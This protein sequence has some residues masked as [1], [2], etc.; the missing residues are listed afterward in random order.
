MRTTKQNHTLVRRKHQGPNMV[1]NLNHQLT[2]SAAAAPHPRFSK[3]D[4]SHFLHL[5]PNNRKEP[6]SSNPV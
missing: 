4:P 3:T 2:V 1:V 5:Y 6:Q